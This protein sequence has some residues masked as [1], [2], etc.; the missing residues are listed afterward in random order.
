MFYDPVPTHV[1]LVLLTHQ[2]G[3]FNILPLYVVLMLM[4]PGFALIDRYAP[5]LVLPVS[6]AMYVLTL[7][8]RISLPNWPLEGEWFFNPMAWQLVFV[9]GFT[10][11]RNDGAGAFARRHLRAI[12]IA[13]LPI[14]IVG[15][16]VVLLDWWPDPTTVPEPKMFFLLDKTYVTP[17]RLLQFLALISVVSFAYPYVRRFASPLVEFLSLLGRHSLP[18]FCVGSILS[19]FGQIVRFLYQGNI[20]VDTAVVIFGIA[21]LALTAWLPEWRESTKVGSSERVTAPLS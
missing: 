19:L 16:L 9:L 1:G 3:Y 12:R 15:L 18:V 5:S 6:L 21:I 13:A 17:G 14:L 20:A 7:V 8:F 4:A 10:L 2:L 11:A